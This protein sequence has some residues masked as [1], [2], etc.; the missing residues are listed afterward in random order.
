MT[1]TVFLKEMAEIINGA[2]ECSTN[3][4]LKR[5]VHLIGN[6]NYRV[7]NPYRMFHQ[8]ASCF[9]RMLMNLAMGMSEKE[10]RQMMEKLTDRILEAA[11]SYEGDCIN[12]NHSQI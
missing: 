11:E 5:Q 4:R 9:I 12:N 1:E 8:Y 3:G 2:I 6:F 10:F 7:F